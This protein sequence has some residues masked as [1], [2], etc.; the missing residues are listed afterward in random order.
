MI[1]LGAGRR[2]GAVVVL[3]F[4]SL[5]LRAAMKLYQR[6]AISL[7]SLRIAL[8]AIRSLERAGALLA[9]GRRRQPDQSTPNQEEF[10]DRVD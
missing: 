1:L 7:P 2:W 10:H 3:R 9:L 8:S 6:R 5:I 4:A